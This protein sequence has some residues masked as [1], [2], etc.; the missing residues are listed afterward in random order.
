MIFSLIVLFLM[1]KGVIKWWYE[2]FMVE[3]DVWRIV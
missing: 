2:L 3:T 1:Y